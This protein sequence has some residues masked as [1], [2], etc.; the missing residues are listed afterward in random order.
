MDDI[1][2][3]QAMSRRRTCR[4]FEAREIPS[5]SL[6]RLLW[7]A[8]GITDES[9]NR[10]IPSAHALHPLRLLVVAGHIEDLQAGVYSVDKDVQRLTLTVQRDVRPEL[11]NAALEDQPWIGAAAGII[12]I[13][14]DFIA[15]SNVFADQPPFGTRGSRYVYVEAGAA[16]Q[17]V[18]LQ[19]VA[20]GI[21]C[22]LVAGFKD[23]ATAEA[24]GVTAPIAPV[25]HLCLG[26]PAHTLAPAK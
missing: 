21:G 10:T 19:A 13:C 9:G 4:D 24:L 26:W 15:P 20:E 23:E 16:A 25:L 1:P 11:Q 7:A 22:V 8:Q 14:A 12:S 2:L 3:N 5:S 6:Q 18:Q 17:N